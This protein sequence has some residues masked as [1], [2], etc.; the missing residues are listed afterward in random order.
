[1]GG[2][3]PIMDHPTF[4]CSKDAE[5]G[6]LLPWGFRRPE[7]VEQQGLNMVGRSKAS[8]QYAANLLYSTLQYSVG[9]IQCI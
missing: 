2:L 5:Y 4:S 9:Q 8:A 6:G 3:Y 1:M 7:T